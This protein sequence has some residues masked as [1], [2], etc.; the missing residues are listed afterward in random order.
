MA[1]EASLGDESTT[2]TVKSSASLMGDLEEIRSKVDRFQSRQDF[3][4]IKLVKQK[5]QA[6]VS[7]YRYVFTIILPQHSILIA[8]HRS[9]PKTTLECW[10]E[11]N[12]F[13]A[14]VAQAEQVR[15]LP[16]EYC[17]ILT[18]IWS[19]VFYRNI[20]ILYGDLVL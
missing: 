5:G 19:L 18:L 2:G 8:R 17:E 3:E 11:V 6:V 10:R 14:S 1:G 4:G 9:H 16:V 12:E 13:K 20:T 7:C 15:P